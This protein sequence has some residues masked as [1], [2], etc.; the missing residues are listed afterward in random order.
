MEW[1]LWTIIV[2][3]QYG[4]TEGYKAAQY[5]YLLRGRAARILG[6]L[7]GMRDSDRMTL[8]LRSIRSLQTPEESAFLVEFICDVAWLLRPS[9][10]TGDQT[11]RSPDYPGMMLPGYQLHRLLA[12]MEWTVPPAYQLL[13]PADKQRVRG[14]IDSSFSYVS[15]SIEN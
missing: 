7:P 13:I 2:E 3:P 10:K 15:S 11:G 8:A 5:Y 1:G 12:G 6:V 9:T 14:V 4:D